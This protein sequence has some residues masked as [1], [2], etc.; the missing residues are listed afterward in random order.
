M[1]KMLYGLLLKSF[2][3]AHKSEQNNPVQ[4]ILD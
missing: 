4:N 2:S 1:P 3:V